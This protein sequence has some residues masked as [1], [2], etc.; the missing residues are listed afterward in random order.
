MPVRH[1]LAAAATAAGAIAALGLTVVPAAQ[2]SPS[3]VPYLSHFSNLKTIAS[4]VPHNG[5][6]NPFGLAVRPGR[7]G[8]YYVDDAVNTLRLL[9]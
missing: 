3:V 6:V 9:H 8:I 7:G 4:T 1:R 5:N 2:A